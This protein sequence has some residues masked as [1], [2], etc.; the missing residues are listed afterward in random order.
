M[1]I[2][3]IELSSKE[4]EDLRSR[5]TAVLDDHKIYYE[6]REVEL[7]HTESIGSGK[8]YIFRNWF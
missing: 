8:E 4:A 2:Q 1:R 6:I 7:F 5:V 3:K